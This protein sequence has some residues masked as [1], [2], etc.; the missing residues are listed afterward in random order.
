MHGSGGCP[1]VL[2]SEGT[3][4]RPVTSDVLPKEM[5]KP[6][7]YVEITVIGHL[8]GRMLADP[9]V[10]GRQMATRNWWPTATTTYRLFVSRLVIDE[11]GA[12]DDTAAS[13]RLAVVDSL[14]F[15]T[16]SVQAEKLAAELVAG[17]A[18][19]DTEPRDAAHI[20]LAAVNGI[21]YLV[22]WN[23]KHIANAMTRG[24][25]ESVCR[26]TGYEPPIICTPDEL[27]EVWNAQ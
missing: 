3:G 19:P 7:V 20:S 18:I 17:H 21:E 10:A 14:E 15:L 2:K 1:V 25:I 22:T 11:C 16:A 5:T 9:V 6:T 23:F 12:G 27:S 4:R 13:E 26:S 8:V 24:A